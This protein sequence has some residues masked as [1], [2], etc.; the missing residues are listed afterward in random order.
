[1]Q[2]LLAPEE[3]R[4]WDEGQLFRCLLQGSEGV[5]PE[6]PHDRHLAHELREHYP[7]A[8]TPALA[9]RS[10]C[11]RVPP[12]HGLRGEPFRVKLGRIRVVLLIVVN[13][14]DGNVDVCAL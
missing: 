10:E 14:D 8:D 1:M 3:Q 5:F 4:L 2:L 9:V 7:D 13:A 6:H 12:R 11:Q